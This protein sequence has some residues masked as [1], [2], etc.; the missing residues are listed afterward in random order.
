MTINEGTTDRIVRIIVGLALIAWFFLDRG[1]GLWHYA[2][3]IG[4]VPLVTGAI[5]TCP[6]YS[7]L[8]ISTCP[9]KT[10]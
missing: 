10:A 1:Q 8:G 3:L 7:M 4:I 2:K 9:V 5:G 6:I